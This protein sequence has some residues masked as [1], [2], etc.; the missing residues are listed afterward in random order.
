ML[1]I[2]NGADKMDGLWMT[3]IRQPPFPFYYSLLILFLSFLLI[4]SVDLVGP[5]DRASM[6]G[7]V[8]QG[9]ARMAIPQAKRGEVMAWVARWVKAIDGVRNDRSGTGKQNWM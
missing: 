4:L 3:E 7:K 6:K 2:D 8:G 1:R 9:T 5:G